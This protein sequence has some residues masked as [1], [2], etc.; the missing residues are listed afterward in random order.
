M[1]VKGV[2]Q[3]YFPF[4]SNM[5][6]GEMQLHGGWSGCRINYLSASKYRVWLPLIRIGYVHNTHWVLDGCFATWLPSVQLCLSTLNVRSGE[7]IRVDNPFNLKWDYTFITRLRKCQV[8]DKFEL[9][10][11][12]FPIAVQKMHYSSGEA[13]GTIT[14][15]IILVIRQ[16]GIELVACSS[17]SNYCFHWL[18]ENYSTFCLLK[19][20]YISP[21]CVQ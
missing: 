1:P 19:L 4:R 20:L 11:L 14:L 16:S 5:W 10:Q 6:S 21:M 2:V 13:K 9:I 17:K 15:I 18:L 12:G 7:S 3:A 8:P